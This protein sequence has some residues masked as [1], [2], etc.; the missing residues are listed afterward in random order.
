MK[1]PPRSESNEMP[2]LTPMIDIVFLLIVFFMTV[3]KMK[4]EESIPIEVPIADQA[5]VAEER[6]TR[7]TLTLTSEGEL[8][9]GPQAVTVDALPGMIEALRADSPQLQVYLRADAGVPYRLIQEVMENAASGGVPTVVFG[10]Y[11]S[12]K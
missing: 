12:D 7:L 9:A 4:V 8:F 6:G 2:D 11:Q 10:T 3:A 5:V 1:P